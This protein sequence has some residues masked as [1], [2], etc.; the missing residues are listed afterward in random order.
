MPYL[1]NTLS[2]VLSQSFT[3]C[4]YAA[5]A[6]PITLKAGEIQLKKKIEHLCCR[7]LLVQIAIK[8]ENRFLKGVPGFGVGLR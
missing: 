6:C 5:N 2:G 8:R 3:M 7:T 1:N 4:W